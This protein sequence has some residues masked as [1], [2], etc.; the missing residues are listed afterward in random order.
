MAQEI[1][2]QLKEH[3]D[4]WTRVDAILE[5]S[6]NPQT[7]YYALQIL[8]KLVSTR[9]KTLP[10]EQCD[11]EY[12]NFF[13]SAPHFI[14]PSLAGIKNYIVGLV[15]NISSNPTL[16]EQEKLYISKLNMVLVQVN[17][18][19]LLLFIHFYLGSLFR[20]SNANGPKIGP[21][22]FRTSSVPAGRTNRCAR[23][24]WSS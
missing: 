21:L 20:L 4:S 12:L 6:K 3:P 7:K 1:L 14:R 13:I 5:F 15:I 22:S 11:G 9:W 24:I 10:R 18:R 8:E 16:L 2:T 17:P 19:S 23:T